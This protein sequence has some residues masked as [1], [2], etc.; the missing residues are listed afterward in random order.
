MITDAQ[1]RN[2]IIRQIQRIPPEK[3]KELEDFILKLDE[4][5]N[6]KAKILSF[7]GAWKNID[8]S[9]LNDLTENLI[10]SRLKNK[11]RFDD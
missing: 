2:Q 4:S 10:S 9:V 11:R 3:L 5:K 7:A 1:I 8:G 6:K